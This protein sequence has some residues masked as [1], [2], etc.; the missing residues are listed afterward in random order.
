MKLN[1]TT[2]ALLALWLIPGLGPKKIQKLVDSFSSVDKIFGASYQSLRE[3]LGLTEDQIIHDIP[4]A[5]DSDILKRE[6]E[7]IDKYDVRILD[8]TQKSYPP[9]LKEIYNAPPILYLRGNYTFSSSFSLAFVG[10][11]KA[12]Y[13]GKN[14]CKR[15]IKS[16]SVK[17]PETTIISGLALGID[18]AAHESAVENG[19]N[20]IAVLANGLSEVYPVRNK[21]LAK[22]IL[23]NGALISEF[24]LSTKP[25][26]KNFPLRN[27]IISGLAQGVII[28]EAGVR[29]GASITAGYALEQNRELF[30][31]PG[32]AD[33][34]FHK[35]TNRL[36]Q[37]GHA[38]LVMELDDI[39]EEFQD[40]NKQLSI[41]EKIS[42]GV[43][44][45]P[46]L[47]PDEITVLELIQQGCTQKD[48]LIEQ[49]GLPVQKLLST[50]VTLEI[51]GYIAS[52]PGASF[53]LVHK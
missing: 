49:S 30:A 10:S 47:E 7:Y 20:T 12:S 27:R 19:L 18:T 53:E 6:L 48:S 5:L 41:D 9:A 1:E 29:S 3:I 14:I 51:K 2:L 13:S 4:G 32:P 24:P 42:P 45:E 46:D 8:I 38:K 25:I 28:V 35:G 50:L 23:Q 43:I 39:L 22:R 15:F 36:I 33:S 16:L 34:A 11:R 37:K 17:L 21:E 31:L 52:K 40:I 44:L 26:A